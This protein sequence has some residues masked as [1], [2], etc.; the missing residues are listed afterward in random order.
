M[1]EDVSAG[2][3]LLPKRKL[4]PMA[5]S[6]LREEYSS[7]MVYSEREPVSFD[8]GFAALVPERSAPALPLEMAVHK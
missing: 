6:S 8:R 7:Y 4:R 5:G 3:W 2:S 1:A